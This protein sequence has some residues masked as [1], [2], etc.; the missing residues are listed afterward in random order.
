MHRANDNYSKRAFIL[1]AVELLLRPSLP[2]RRRA[3]DGGFAPWEAFKQ[4]RRRQQKLKTSAWYQ[5]V[6]DGLVRTHEG[7]LREAC[8]PRITAR[9]KRLRRVAQGAEVHRLTL[10]GLPSNL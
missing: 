8:A 10:R 6:D 1:C 5:V 2:T 3:R 4:A 9:R 7:T